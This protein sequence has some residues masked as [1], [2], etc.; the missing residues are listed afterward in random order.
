[1]TKVRKDNN[2]QYKAGH[3]EAFFGFFSR[4]FY[5]IKMEKNPKMNPDFFFGFF[6]PFLLHKKI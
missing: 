4:F 5:V 1:M 6:F 2:T 3:A